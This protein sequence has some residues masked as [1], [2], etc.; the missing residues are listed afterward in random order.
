MRTDR[1]APDAV[2]TVY[3]RAR[4]LTRP[5]WKVLG[6][7]AL[8]SPLYI[9]GAL[10]LTIG[11]WRDDTWLKVAVGS[12]A[13][14]V[15]ALLFLEITS[16]P[17]AAVISARGVVFR[18]RLHSERREWASFDPLVKPAWGPWADGGWWISYPLGRGKDSTKRRGH[19]L[20]DEQAREIL[21]Y[22]SGKNW[23]LTPQIQNL[24]RAGARSETPSP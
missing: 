21:E 16:H 2:G 17:R 10:F 8:M 13:L 15:M 1:A 19:W 24:L 20:T 14:I 7:F 6:L 12:G 11:G 22:P 5:D 18:Y 23:T 4:G 3:V 9:L